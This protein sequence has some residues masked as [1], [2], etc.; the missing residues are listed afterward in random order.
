M[1]VLLLFICLYPFFSSRRRHTRWNCDWSSDVCS[2]DLRCA[3]IA[4]STTWPHSDESF[5][6]SSGLI[7][8]VAEIS[9][10]FRTMIFG[11]EALWRMGFELHFCN[12][13]MRN[14]L[15]RRDK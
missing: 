14:A 11:L 10:L 2:S 3:P 1:S 6:M 9:A 7:F 13:E 5:A 8:R 4:F 15:E 12:G